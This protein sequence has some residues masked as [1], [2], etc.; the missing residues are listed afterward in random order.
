MYTHTRARARLERAKRVWRQQPAVAR[1]PRATLQSHHTWQ[2]QT[3]NNSRR[4]PPQVQVDESER[5]GV[6]NLISGIATGMSGERQPSA[7]E[8]AEMNA[9]IQ[10]QHRESIER[11][12]QQKVLKIVAQMSHEVAAVYKDVGSDQLPDWCH[13]L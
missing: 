3:T 11:D 4:P 8:M 5:S 1:L 7:A 2:P 10:R 6:G 13:D 9:H 12:Q